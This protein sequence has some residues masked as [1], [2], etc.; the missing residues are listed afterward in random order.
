MTNDIG[1][2]F[3]VFGTSTPKFQDEELR[4]KDLRVFKN[5]NGNT[6]LL[7]SFL[8]KDTLLITGNENIFS[9]ILGKYLIQKAIP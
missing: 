2:W 8:D 9:A 5:E 7:Y 6:I 3:G 4:N 1:A